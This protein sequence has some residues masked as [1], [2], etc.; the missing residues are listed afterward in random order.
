MRLNEV[1]AKKHFG[2]TTGGGW[3]Y[4]PVTK[5]QCGAFMLSANESPLRL[6]AGYIIEGIYEDDRSGMALRISNF[7]AYAV[8]P[9]DVIKIIDKVL[10]MKAK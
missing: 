6:D 8:N 7:K 9:A 2:Q 1:I 4:N 5:R 3:I 10:K